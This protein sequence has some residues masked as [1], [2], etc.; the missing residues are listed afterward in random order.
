MS[1]ENDGFRFVGENLALDFVNT[2]ASEGGVVGE[3]LPAFRDARAWFEA[4]GVLSPADARRLL[5]FD[6]SAQARAAL[7][8]LH[9][10]RAV[11]RAMLDELRARGRIGAGYVRAINAALEFC[12]CSRALVSAGTG[13]AVRVQYRFAKPRDLLMVP[14][15]AAAE[16]IAGED[17]SRVK[18]C[19]SECCDIYFLDTSRNR[20][21][22]W[23]EMSACGNRAKAAA[24]YRR[25]RIAGA[26]ARAS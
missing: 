22:T 16:L 18:R 26:A 19:G 4:A 8:E 24:Y 25:S 12:G 21:R 10:F 14:A 7:A 3:A 23:C 2:R 5:R 13:Y 17:L 9:R 6:G 20:S 15:N 1:G 11:L